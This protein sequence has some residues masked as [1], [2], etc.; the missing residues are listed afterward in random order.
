MSFLISIAVHLQVMY[1][2][3]QNIFSFRLAWTG[4]LPIARMVEATEKDVG[5]VEELDGMRSRRFPFD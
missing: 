4:L 3:I 5:A 2:L 1:P